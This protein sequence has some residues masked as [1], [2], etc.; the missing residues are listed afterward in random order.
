MKGV[1]VL[2]DIPAI[3]AVGTASDI[4]DV[5][6]DVIERNYGMAAFKTGILIAKEAIRY[7]SP[8]GFAIITAIDIAVS[9]Y[10]LVKD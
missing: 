3:G 5:G 10:D 4:L 7:T 1:K 9:V 2:K 6:N 8:V